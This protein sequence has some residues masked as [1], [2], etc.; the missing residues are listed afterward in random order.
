[1]AIQVTN[2]SSQLSGKTLIDAE[3][4][5]T[6]SGAKTFS[7]VP[8]FSVTPIVNAGLKF[9]SVQVPSVDPNTLDD[10]EELSW[11]PTYVS[12]G[13]GAPTYSAQVGASV[14]IGRIVHFMIRIITS[15]VAGLNAGTITIAGLPYTSD[16]TGHWPAYV[17]YWA[18]MAST[19]DVFTA[20]VT[21]ASTNIQILGATGPTS[22]VAG[23]TKADF[24]NATDVIVGG[25]YLANS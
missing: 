17:S 5:Q 1:M 18:G 3:D 21:A 6:I 7:G 22:T 14:K 2:T 25:F 10:Y 8:T 9:P 12:S 16:G 4:T 13:G 24:S 20:F 23:L 19:L 11:T 15:S